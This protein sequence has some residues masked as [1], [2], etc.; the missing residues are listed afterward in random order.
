MHAQS[1]NTARRRG[2]NKELTVDDFFQSKPQP[3]QSLKQF[4]EN[5]K[6]KL[7]HLESNEQLNTKFMEKI[8]KLKQDKRKLSK[9]I[10]N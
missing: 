4:K 1:M 7:H 8:N 9:K 3:P 2:A 10:Y 5:L 6:F